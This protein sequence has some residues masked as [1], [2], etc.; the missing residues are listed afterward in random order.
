M[1]TWNQIKASFPA[2]RLVKDD[3]YEIT[4]CDERGISAQRVATG[5]TVRA[6][7]RM[8]EKTAQRLEAG[9][10]IPR[11]GISYTVAIETLVVIALGSSIAE[12]TRDGERGYVAGK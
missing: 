9:E 7:R 5:S 11:R 1:R 12:A 4:G 3:A 10:F 6:S 8:I 2:G